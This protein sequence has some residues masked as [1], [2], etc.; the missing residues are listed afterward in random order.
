MRSSIRKFWRRLEKTV[1]PDDAE[2]L[3]RHEHT[4]NLDFPPP[5]F[6]GDVDNAPIVILMANGGYDPHKITGTQSEFLEP[7]DFAEH[8]QMLQSER[9]CIPRRLSPYY[10]ENT[11]F[12]WV[13]GGSAV[14]VNAVAYRSPKITEEPQN[15]EVARILPSARVHKEWLLEE[16]LPAAERGQRCVVA[17][18]RRLWKLPKKIIFHGMFICPQIPFPPTCREISLPSLVLGFDSIG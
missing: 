7:S 16:V 8:L 6:I 10:T 17:H 14:I 1:H 3:S 11:V 9:I 15:Q 13:R 2:V 12:P 5:A 4:F 18:R